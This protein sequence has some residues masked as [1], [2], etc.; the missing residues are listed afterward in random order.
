M[1]QRQFS[2]FNA[3][4]TKY[5]ANDSAGITTVGELHRKI[6]SDRELEQLTNHARHIREMQG[7]KAYNAFKEE[8]MPFFTAAGIFSHRDEKGLIY[9]TGDFV[10]DIDGLP[11]KDRARKLRDT[12]F[13]DHVLQPDLT[14]V[15]LSNYGIKMCVPYVEKVNFVLLDCFTEAV[16]AAWAYLDVK[17]G[18]GK[19]IDQKNIDIARACFLAHDA[20][21]KMR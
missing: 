15:S 19:Y 4:I 1:E 6:T 5:K 8:K 18:L 10:I 16:R 7:V 11:T 3:P 21:A 17:Y 12:L 14:L 9:L 2:I 13:N 20:E